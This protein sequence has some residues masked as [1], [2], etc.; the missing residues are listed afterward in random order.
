M[1]LR[2]VRFQYQPGR[3]STKDGVLPYLPIT[4]RHHTQSLSAIG[5]VDSGASV[6]VLPYSK[7]VELGAV[8]EQQTIQ[9]E[10]SGNLAAVEAR[11]L[12]LTTTI[13]RFNPVRLAF[14]WARS[15]SVP[16]VLGQMNFFQEFDICF[17]RAE[18]AFEI[19]PRHSNQN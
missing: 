14:A 12:L 11:G 18:M 6:N 1:T 13:A 16:L 19:Q 8:W 15:D 10:L 3:S 7:G 5:L 4:L 2:P 17:F 9:L